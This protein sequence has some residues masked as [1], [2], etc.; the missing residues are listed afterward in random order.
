MSFDPRRIFNIEV[1]GNAILIL[2][3]AVLACI[4]LF[5]R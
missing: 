2:S 1:A 3:F 4:V 5:V